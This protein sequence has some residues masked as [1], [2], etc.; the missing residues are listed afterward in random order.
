MGGRRGAVVRHYV[1]VLVGAAA[2]GLLVL[3]APTVAPGATTSSSTAP[4]GAPVYPAGDAPEDAGVAASG[5]HCG[6]D[7]RQVTW[8]KYAPLCQPAFDG[9]NGGA[10]SPGVTATTITVTSRYAATEAEQALFNQLAPGAVAGQGQTEALAQAYVSLFNR[11]FDLYG[12]KVVLKPFDGKGDFLSELSGTGQAGAEADAATA[13]SMGAFA[14]VSDT[15]FNTQPY[16][17][18][19]AA[20][21]VISVGGMFAS[22]SQMRAEAPYEYFPGPDCEKTATSSAALIARAM[23]GMPAVFAGSPALARQTRTFALISPDNPEYAA[24]GQAVVNDLA[25]EYGIHLKTWIKYTLS[26]DAITQAASQATATVTQLKTDGVTTVVC[27]CDPIT[28][29]FLA[30]D[31]AQQGY[32][33]EWL[34]L[35]FGDTFSQ[36]ASDASPAEWDHAL[37]GGTAPVP[38]DQQEA[39]VAYRLAVGNPRAVPPAG[40]QFV[41]EPLLQLF[42]ALQAAG[43]DLTPQS[44]AAGMD[45]LPSSLPGGQFGPWTFGPGTLDP[46]AGFQVLRWDSQVVSTEDGQ[47]GT[48]LPCNDGA[49]YLYA[50]DAA[51]LP[52]HRQ[53]DCPAVP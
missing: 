8:S 15:I 7:A 20:Q 14:D 43:P 1:P 41:Y 2:L 51:S 23:A 33:P 28:P 46:A 11:T 25:R 3:L 49:V 10:T 5:A 45:S 29:L 38:E 50:D 34:T 32:D 52:D 4:V 47:P 9:D 30:K 42:D 6:G 22:A 48:G 21:H 31:A 40:Y 18:A 37:Y 26:L 36:L 39:V 53:L 44:F 16:N 24:C 17:D 19:L 13:R 35:D 12:R 27:G